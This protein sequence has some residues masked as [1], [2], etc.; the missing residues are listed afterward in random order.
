MSG[1]IEGEDRHQATLF[2]ERLDD[3]IAEESAVRVIDV[4]IDDLDLVGFGVQDGPSSNGPS[5]LPC[6]N[7]VEALRLRLPQPCC[8]HP[9]AWSAKHSATWS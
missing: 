1:F 6:V 5:R 2:P 9:A 7:P 3:Y 4:F 8:S